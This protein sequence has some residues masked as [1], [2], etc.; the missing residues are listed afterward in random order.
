[1]KHT[2]R[3]ACLALSLSALTGAASAQVSTLP[4]ALQ[5]SCDNTLTQ[6]D[7][8]DLSLR[9][10]GNLTLQGDITLQRS[11]SITL[12]AAQDLSLSGVSLVAPSI[13]LT[14]I[15]GRLLLAP[16]VVLNSSGAITL[17]SPT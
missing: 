8:P 9:C 2:T 3:S 7:G 4:D 16:D 14:T 13:T 15:G 5:L 17:N 11:G 6:L 12:E 10:A 1:M